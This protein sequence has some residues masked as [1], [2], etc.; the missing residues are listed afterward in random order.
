MHRV[1][2]AC[3][4]VGGVKCWSGCWDICSSAYNCSTSA[5]CECAATCVVAA[6]ACV[7][8]MPCTCRPR[9]A[10]V[11]SILDMR[12]NR[13]AGHV[14][15]VQLAASGQPLLLLACRSHWPLCGERQRGRYSRAEQ[16]A[17]HGN[18][19]EDMR[20][21]AAGWCMC[22]CLFACAL[23]CVRVRLRVRR[24]FVSVVCAYIHASVRACIRTP[25]RS[26]CWA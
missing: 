8:R 24:L 20:L 18:A 26:S 13:S 1:S 14:A 11:A 12:R 6:T 23:G 19:S 15:I 4:W 7:P 25:S 16:L 9:A 17:I 5:S 10:H 22:A 2:R 3:A 21:C